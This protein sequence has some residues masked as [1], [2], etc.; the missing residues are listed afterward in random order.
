MNP[1][2]LSF[3]ENV[4]FGFVLLFILDGGITYVALSFF[5]LCFL[6]LNPLVSYII[7]TNGLFFATITFKL[8]LAVVIYL[9]GRVAFSQL[10]KKQTPS[11]ERKFAGLLV[12][13]I[14]FLYLFV[15]GSNSYQILMVM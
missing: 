5:P 15:V 8:A 1:F 11:S 3:V 2:D 4:Y 14:F 10:A 13:S 7:L 9:L 6:E 12:Y